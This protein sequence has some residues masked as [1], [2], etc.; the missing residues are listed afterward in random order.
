MPRKSTRNAQGT[1]SIRQRSD[2]RWEARFTYTDELGQ[3]KRGSVYS[4]NQKECRKKLIAALKAVDDGSYVKAQRYTVSQ[5]LDE[6]LSTYCKDLKP[7]TV[8]GYRSKIDTRIKPYIG[9]SALTALTNVQIQ[10][11]Y[12]KLQ[13]GDK[14]YKPLSPKSIQSIHGILHKSLDQAVSARIIGSNPADHIKLPK[15][16]R[17]ELT[18]IMDDDV[19]RFLEAIKGDRF[20][21]L[22]ILDL[23]SGLRQSEIVGLQ[24]DDVDL[25][26]GLLTVRRQIQ[27]SYSG[28]G[29][30]FLDETKNGKQR[31]VAIAPSIVQVLKAQKIQQAKW[32]LAAGPLWNN[33]R[34]LVFTD[35]LGGHLKH[36]TIY[37]H[38]KKIVT[39]IGLESTRFHDL[40]HSFA[41]NALQAGDSYKVVQEQMGHYS[42][43]FTMDV[44][45]AV[46]DTMR[47]DS[48][49]RMEGLFKAVSGCKG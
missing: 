44:Y 20:E 32:Q 15:I 25:E 21:R 7:A 17:P 18:P 40:R 4:D 48:Q 23:F 19:S 27:K 35:E 42:S 29:Y 47:K 34:N 12:N 11:F 26:A 36:R 30:V 24:W 39:S 14:E 45:A 41:I 28:D 33:S 1:G 37:N 5:W 43:A 6:W 22:Y 8:S 13:D 16:K 10:K 2:G 38:F 3:K 31:I 46:S 9:N 49:E